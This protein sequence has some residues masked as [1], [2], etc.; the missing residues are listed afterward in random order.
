MRA[1][2]ALLGALCA[3]ASLPAAAHAHP[4]GNFSVN[5]L[6]EVSV[7]A[8]RVD[9]RYVLDQAEIPTFQQR[10]LARA[11][12]L[13]RIRAEVARG[14]RV[15]VDGRP[16]ALRAVA[17]P[18][19][20][21]RPGAGGL[22]TTRFE[23]ALRAP[24]RDARRV[25]LRDDTFRD[26]VGWRAI[27][28]KPGRDTAVRTA[29]PATDPTRRLTRYPAALLE[30]PAD[31]RAAR[32]DVRPGDGT[33]VAGGERR[34][35]AGGSAA[36]GFAGLFA[37]AAAG[38]GVL[39]LLLLAAFG[40]GAVHAL[41]PGHGKA[42]V[43]A[44][45]VGTRG[46]ARQA[47]A[48]GATVTV[49]HTAGVALLGVVAL[50]LSQYVLPEDLYPWLNLAAGLLVLGVGAAV[51]RGRVARKRQHHHHHDHSH[52]PPDTLSARGLV[53]MGVSAGLIP[54]PSALVVLLGAVAQ[55]QIALGLLLIVA[56]SAGLAATLTALG[57]AV[58]WTTRAAGRL[59]V[60]GRALAALP[61]LSAIAIVG[62]GILLTAQALPQV[63]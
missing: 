19:L 38:E 60:P 4:L 13:R 15:T 45:L 24:A 43:A 52:A 28:V 44:Y 25:V 16:A 49:T 51:L 20:A 59:K 11:E 3:L 18:R 22:R 53:A 9:V 14:V 10:G 29:A 55:H 12:L 61:T 35:A 1:R 54:C 62:I 42:M 26:R 36:D 23:L 31:L 40:W 47:V 50:T 63:A 48:L 39:L 41:S 34:S 58:V 37:D 2:L 30:S 57:L 46:T 27:V 5:H 21:L 56:F 6:A 8:D 33:L 7:S 17:P 32:L